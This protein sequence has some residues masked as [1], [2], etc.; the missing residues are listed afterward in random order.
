MELIISGVVI[1]VVGFVAGVLVGRN[2]ANK[3]EAL[4]QEAKEALDKV[5]SKVDDL[6]TKVD[7]VDAKVEEVKIAPVFPVVDE[8]KPAPANII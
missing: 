6:K 7:V 1:A 8:N 3:V 2:N 4:V 5:H